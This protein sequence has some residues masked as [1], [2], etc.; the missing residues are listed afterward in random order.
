MGLSFAE[1]LIQS[2]TT[3]FKV[4]KFYS[5]HLLL[6]ATLGGDGSDDGGG[7]GEAVAG[8]NTEEEAEAGWV[9]LNKVRCVSAELQMLEKMTM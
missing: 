4:L 9:K 2:C 1:K 8:G 6:F 3:S 5:Q 7:E